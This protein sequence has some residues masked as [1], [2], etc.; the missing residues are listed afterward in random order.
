MQPRHSGR[1]RRGWSG[2]RFT[3]RHSVD[4][5]VGGTVNQ[6]PRCRTLQIDN[7]LTVPFTFHPW[8]HI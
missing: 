4:T 1:I 6:L 3:L 7:F 5:V 8:L 2:Q